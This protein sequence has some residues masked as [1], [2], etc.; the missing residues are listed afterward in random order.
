MQGV[1]T[2]RIFLDRGSVEVFGN[3]GECVVTSLIFPEG[4]RSGLEFYAL[5]GAARLVALD[6]YHLY[7]R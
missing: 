6:V 2:L 4:D 7:A 1:I 3:D 5:G